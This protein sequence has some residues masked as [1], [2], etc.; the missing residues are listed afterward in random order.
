MM[1]GVNVI[2]SGCMSVSISDEHLRQVSNK[3]T[4]NTSADH[5]ITY[6][7]RPQVLPTHCVA[8]TTPRYH[9]KFRRHHILPRASGSCSHPSYPSSPTTI[10]MPLRR[11]THQHQQQPVHYRHPRSTSSTTTTILI[12]CSPT[13]SHRSTALLHRR[14]RI[15]H[16]PRTART[17]RQQ[18]R[19]HTHRPFQR[20]HFRLSSP[21]LLHFDPPLR[22]SV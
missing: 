17:R 16:H 12:P 5:T 19:R 18:Q 4:N 11:H 13:R 8:A 3:M 10:V 20:R 6:E 22:R 7:Q 1:P 21:P 14:R 9:A 2:T 15:K